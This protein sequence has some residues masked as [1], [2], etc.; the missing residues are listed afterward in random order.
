MSIK[1]AIRQFDPQP[2][3]IQ[4]KLAMAQ[5]IELELKKKSFDIEKNGV[6]LRVDGTGEP[7]SINITPNLGK[8]ATNQAVLDVMTEAFWMI[9]KMR[10][11]AA[12][13]CFGDF[14]VTKPR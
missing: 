2:N 3:P 6:T 9:A 7:I 8:V 13:E 5:N 11:D 14:P 1:S 4:V 12:R 10:D